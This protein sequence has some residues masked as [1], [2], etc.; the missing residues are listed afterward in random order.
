MSVGVLASHLSMGDGMDGP[1]S[2]KDETDSTSFL[3]SLTAEIKD[4]NKSHF[5]G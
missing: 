1:R 5:R 2:H 3:V 4:P